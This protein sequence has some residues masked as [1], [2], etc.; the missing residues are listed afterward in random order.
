[1]ADTTL[2]ERLAALIESMSVERARLIADARGRVGS[3]REDREREI[4]RLSGRIAVQRAT[5]DRLG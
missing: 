4:E 3:A 1:M 2:R 5:L